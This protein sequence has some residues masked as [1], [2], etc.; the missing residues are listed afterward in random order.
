MNDA[1][2]EVNKRIALSLL[3][4]DPAMKQLAN[5]IGIK[6]IRRRLKNYNWDNDLNDLVEPIHFK[7]WA[8]SL[9]EGLS[10]VIEEVYPAKEVPEDEFL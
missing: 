2:A 1:I 6:E 3:E 9:P 7:L 4:C 8:L 5:Q 10:K